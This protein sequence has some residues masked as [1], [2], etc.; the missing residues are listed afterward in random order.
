VSFINKKT[1]Q[2]FSCPFSFAC[3][4]KRIIELIINP[5]IPFDLYCFI[6]YNI[7]QYRR[8]AKALQIETAY[9][10]VIRLSYNRV[11]KM[12]KK[13]KK[14]SNYNIYFEDSLDCSDMV[15]SSTDCTGLVQKPPA[16]ETQA[17]S[18]AD[19]HKIP[20]PRDYRNELTKQH[21]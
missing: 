11:T 18:Y 13:N 8:R 21:K 17:E 4:N 12:E 7:N 3:G 19:L 15:A 10:P 5:F 9:F 6:R 20:K 1:G 16:D 2:D 14:K